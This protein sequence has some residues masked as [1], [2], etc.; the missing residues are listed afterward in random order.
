MI[1]RPNRRTGPSIQELRKIEVTT[2]ETKNKETQV[3]EAIILYVNTTRSLL[4]TKSFTPCPDA[5][6]ITGTHIIAVLIR[7]RYSARHSHFPF[8]SNDINRK[9]P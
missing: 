2:I 1:K 3:V 5:D 9:G 6:K 8:L 4:M 7:K